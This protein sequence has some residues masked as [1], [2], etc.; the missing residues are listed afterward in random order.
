MVLTWPHNLIVWSRE[1]SRGKEL[2]GPVLLAQHS[3]LVY[4]IILIVL[5]SLFQSLVLRDQIIFVGVFH[6]WSG[7]LKLRV[8]P[9]RRAADHTSLLLLF[10]ELTL[11][12]RL[13]GRGSLLLAL[14]SWIF[15]V[16]SL[17]VYWICIWVFSSNLWCGPFLNGSYRTSVVAWFEKLEGWSRCQIRFILLLYAFSC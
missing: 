14:V 17:N 16:E 8:V 11:V 1:E 13:Q 6:G 4:L 3:L 10:E 9:K 15:N 2:L 12:A 5:L 7:C